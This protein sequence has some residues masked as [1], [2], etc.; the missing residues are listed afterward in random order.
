MKVSIIGLGYV[1]LP[2]A[3]VAA[4]NRN[5]NVIGVDKDSKKVNSIKSGVCPIPEDEFIADMFEKNR[6]EVTVNTAASD[7]YIVCV[8]TPVR[9]KS[10]P[11]LSY[12]ISAVRDI[13]QVVRD[14]DLVIIE[15]TIYPGVCDEIVQPILEE[16]RKKVHLAHCPERI[17]PGDK[18]WTVKNIPRVV[19]ADS[20]EATKRALDFYTQILDSKITPVSQ[21]KAAEA[22]K[23][24]ENTFRDINIAFA[25]E[26]AKSFYS[27]G[28]D[29]EEVIR[30]ASTKP[31]AFMAHRPGIGVGGH[32]IAVDPYYMIEKGKEVGFD[33]EFLSLAR[34]INSRM[35]RFGL[36]IVQDALNEVKRPLNGTKIL[37]LGLSY[38]PNVGD[39]RESPSYELIKLLKQKNAIVKVFDPFFPEKSTTDS[40]E[41]GI[42]ES[43]CVIL[44][45]AHTSFLNPELYSN[46]E[47]FVDG[48]NMMNKD[49]LK[50]MGIVYR[51]IGI[52]N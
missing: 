26:M 8:P 11:D 18:K 43:S 42:N 3:L 45:T 17:N 9:Q 2:L 34:K 31:F 35:P 10:L 49:A 19:G 12:I 36:E 21:L 50:S 5:L 41:D 1:G 29:V 27:L 4:Q 47:V 30:G 48:R 20:E 15:S 33:H 24:M 46:I 25:N 32:C 6:L 52:S 39:D 40:L 14:D 37:V 28:I 38:K 16:S 22:T 51:G 44:A 7:I 23:I 13:S